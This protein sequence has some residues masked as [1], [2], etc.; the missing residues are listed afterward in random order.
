MEKRSRTNKE[1]FEQNPMKCAEAIGYLRALTQYFPSEEKWAETE[2]TAL[3][4]RLVFF[5]I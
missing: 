5:S 4:L 3:L 2:K 1:I